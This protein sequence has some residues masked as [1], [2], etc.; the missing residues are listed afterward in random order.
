V[1]CPRSIYERD[2]DEHRYLSC[3]A[4]PFLV[5]LGTTIHT[6]H[7]LQP[8]NRRQIVSQCLLS[9]PQCM[10]LR[11]RPG[12]V[13]VRLPSVTVRAIASRLV[14]CS[15]SHVTISFLPIVSL[16]PSS[17]TGSALVP[18]SGA[19]VIRPTRY[20]VPVNVLPLCLKRLTELDKFSPGSSC[21]NPV[22]PDQ[23]QNDE[24]MSS[25]YNVAVFNAKLRPQKTLRARVAPARPKIRFPP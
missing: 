8:A 16:N 11:R 14:A 3:L 24:N 20:R 9:S 25:S 22:Q 21:C 7:G 19:L 5:A 6:C 12:W 18:L 1:S 17:Q 2:A 13:D 15:T 23:D 10:S 4:L